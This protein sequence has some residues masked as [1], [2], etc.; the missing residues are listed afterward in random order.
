[1]SPPDLQ[2]G[3]AAI[4]DALRTGL[5]GRYDVERELGRGGMATVFLAR[6]LRHGRA[7]AIKVLAHD[8]VASSG[9]ERFLHE[10]R[11]AA[12]LT[13]PHVLALYDSGE[14]NGVLYYVMPYVDGETLRA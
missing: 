11:I 10:I 5:A 9:G 8:V 1:M 12:Q 7:V 4:A 13:H 3:S 14:V 6:D 2:P